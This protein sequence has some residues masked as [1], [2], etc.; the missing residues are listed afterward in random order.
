VLRAERIG[1]RE[2]ALRIPG[3]AAGIAL[4]TALSVGST[5]VSIV[6]ALAPPE[7]GSVPMFYAKVI[8]GCVLFLGLGLV[9]CCSQRNA[10]DTL[11][12]KGRDR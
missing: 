12:Q 2:A 5:L 6:F 10:Q 7:H 8:S 11:T 9:F 1:E 4:I 3:G